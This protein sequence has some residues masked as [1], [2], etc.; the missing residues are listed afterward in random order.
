MVWYNTRMIMRIGFN[1]GILLAIIYMP[2]QSVALFLLAGFFYYDIYIEGI[3]WAM[4]LDVVF[5]GGSSQSYWYTLYACMA[6]GATY[7]LK[8]Y[9]RLYA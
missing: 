9:I 8:P 1:I 4:L 7:A 3:I 5:G 6:W 2:Y